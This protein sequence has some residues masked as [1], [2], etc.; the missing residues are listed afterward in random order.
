MDGQTC[1]QP[2]HGIRPQEEQPSAVQSELVTPACSD[3]AARVGRRV[4]HFLH[5]DASVAAASQSW[6]PTSPTST[7]QNAFA[8]EPC[9]HWPFLSPC[10]LRW[11][12]GKRQQ[13]RSIAGSSE[14]PTLTLPSSSEFFSSWVEKHLSEWRRSEL[15]LAVAEG[16]VPR[17]RFLSQQTAS[18]VRLDPALVSGDTLQPHPQLLLCGSPLG[19]LAAVLWESVR[20]GDCIHPDWSE[21]L[22]VGCPPV[23]PIL[24]LQMSGSIGLRDQWQ[25]P[26]LSLL[27]PQRSQSA[28]PI[29]MPPRASSKGGRGQIL[30]PKTWAEIWQCGK[31]PSSFR[32]LVAAKTGRSSTQGPER[33]WDLFRFTARP[34]SPLFTSRAILFSPSLAGRVCFW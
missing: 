23:S 31:K 32:E 20:L 4:S 10:N 6:F 33:C 3:G 18:M 7:G 2:P 25:C 1:A 21:L 22:M 24:H 13:G 14:D 30:Q 12:P 8:G 9:D 11:L 28:G 29:L 27:G 5:L 16:S 15:P 26:T 17:Q 19:E 34:P